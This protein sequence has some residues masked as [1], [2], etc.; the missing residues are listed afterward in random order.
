MLGFYPFKLSS[1][2]YWNYFEYCNLGLSKG[3]SFQE[4]YNCLKY[5]LSLLSKIFL[6]DGTRAKQT[7]CSICQ[8]AYERWDSVADNVYH[9]AGL[10]SF[11]VALLIYSDKEERK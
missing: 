9:L 11:G 1:L 2:G 8:Y 10:M 3:I 7:L 4:K 5:N 6:A